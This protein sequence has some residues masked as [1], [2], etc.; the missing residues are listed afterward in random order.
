MDSLKPPPPLCL[1]GDLKQNFQK[2]TQQYDIYMIASGTEGDEKIKDKQKKAIYLHCLGAE[3]LTIY[4]GFKNKEKL[5]Y[6][7]VKQKFNEYCS[8]PGNETFSR[9]VFFSRKKRDGESFDEFFCTLRKLAGDC[10]FADLE[11]SLIRDQIILGLNDAK[12]TERL[13]KESTLTLDSCMKI[14]KVAES[15]AKQVQVM[16][17]KTVEAVTRKQESRSRM[18]NQNKT[19]FNNKQHLGKSAEGSVRLKNNNC[20]RCGGVHSHRSCPAFGRRCAKCNR[21]GHYMQM[22]RTVGAVYVSDDDSDDSLV[23][24]S[25][26]V[27]QVDT[28]DWIVEAK[29]RGQKMKFKVDTGSQVNIL[30]SAIVKK[31]DLKMTETCTK[32]KNFDGSTIETVGMTKTI[33]KFNKKKYVLDFYVV[34][35]K[36][37]NVLSY[38]AAVQ[39]GLINKVENISKEYVVQDIG[40]YKDLFHGLG[41]LNYVYKIKLTDNC[42]PVVEPPRKI[43]FKL[44]DKV[45]NEL[46]RLEQLDVI[47]KVQEPTEWVNSMVIVKKSQDKIRLCLDPQNINK[48]IIRERHKI[49]TFEELT[50]AMPDAKY[51]SVLDAN[52]GFYQILLA[53]ESQ[54]LTT[55]NAG[56]FGRYCFKRLPFGLNSAPEVFTKCYSEIF[57]DIQGVVTYVDEI[58]VWGDTKKT[59]DE[60]LLQVLEKARQAGVKFNKEKCV[61]GVK[62]VKYVGHILSSEGLKPDPEKVRAIVDMKEP[63]TKK[64]LQTVLGIITYISKFIPNTSEL[65]ESLRQLLKKNVEYIWGDKQKEDF[66]KIK[67]FLTSATVLRYFDVNKP[68]TLSVDSSSTG[69]GAVLLQDNL[70]VAYG[71]KTLTECQKSWAQIEKEMLAIVYGCEK[72][73]QYIYDKHVIVESDHRPLEYI[74]KKTINETPL[75]LQ[76]LRLRIQGYDLEIRY[77]PGK[78]LFVA[79]ALSRNSL[80]DKICNKDLDQHVEL[81]VCLIT[82]G[83][84]FTEQKLEDFKKKT[85][86]DEECQKIIKNIEMGWPDKVKLPTDLKYYHSIK[87]DLY[88]ANGLIFKNN[89]V[90][91][92]KSLRKEILN[93]IHYNH[94]GLEK[95]KNKIRGLLYWPFM[96][97]ELED[98]IRNCEACLKYQK[99]HS[100]ETLILRD[101]PKQPWDII[102][103]D[104]FFYKN[105]IY[106]MVVDYLT[107]YVEIINMVDQST[108]SHILA[109]KQMFARWGIPTKLCTDDASQFNSYEFQEFVKE[110][111]F[112]LVKSSPYYARSNGMVERHIQIVKKMFKKCDFD[113]KDI[114]MALMEY[115]NTPID[116][117]I[118]MS[119]NE[120]LLGRQTVTLLPTRSSLPGKNKLKKVRNSLQKKQIKYKYYHDRRNNQKGI[121]FTEGQNVFIRDSSS[122]RQRDYNSGDIEDSIGSSGIGSD[123]DN[124]QSN[125]TTSN[126]ESVTLENVN[127]DIRQTRSGRQAY[128]S[129]EREM[130]CE[131]T[132]WNKLWLTCTGDGT[133][134]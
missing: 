59:H 60:R 3:A 107:K 15:A 88:Y 115:R 17:E 64:E 84:K 22:C 26:T 128:L 110:W 49:P 36:T 41:K 30:T 126:R 87:E 12:L 104:M 90:F 24:G 98:H 14:C 35:F 133:T 94:L 62:E 55:F 50:S 85:A 45:K 122:N 11:E 13:L 66:K 78:E 91:V 86:N 52:K 132:Y 31:L 82:E 129:K 69:L 47:K 111:G 99:S 27:G 28:E 38:K 95:C 70:P 80:P 131:D 119:P 48:C 130:S 81:H 120:L 89:A 53:E 76:R 113:Q 105:N 65:T 8:P 44:V 127:T 37:T 20:E 75:R 23:V 100:F 18:P 118:N 16:T 61:I 92:P 116:S 40:E 10:G 72:F 32:L 83:L 2:W 71:S 56:Q 112:Q 33:V 6:V 51:Y 101:I 7:E 46:D 114:Y 77:K 67:Q 109:L 97:K 123:N 42:A 39:L 4:N 29:V 134:E 93:L 21:Y 121:E 43:P 9:H 57:N 54:L 73:H 79:D 63:T 102:G 58:L 124:I 117:E 74:F 108:Q 25:V 34:K 1:M 68:V 19:S 106:L 125:D 103:A 96:N 5:S